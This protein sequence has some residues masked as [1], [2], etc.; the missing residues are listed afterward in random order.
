MAAIDYLTERGFSTK[1]AGMRIRVSPALQ[2]TD[3]V[4][5]F[6]KS[7]RLALLAELG[8]NDQGEQHPQWRMI[9]GGRACPGWI[10]ARDLY[11][12]H[13]MACRACYATT[14]RHCPH[15]ADLRATYDNTPMES[16]P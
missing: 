3:D 15:G 5:Q 16:E 4:R 8:A 6:I 7:H 11:L 1:L 9:Q 10:E 14:G 13:L 12:N 2:L